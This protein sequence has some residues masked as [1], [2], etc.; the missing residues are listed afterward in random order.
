MEQATMDKLTGLFNRWI[1]IQMLEKEFERSIRYAFP[2][3]VCMLDIDHFKSINDRY[4]HVIG[5][6]VLRSVAGII[7]K[8]LRH[9]DISA[10]YGGEEFCA[11]LPHM[12][13]KNA[14][15]I[16]ERIRRAIESAACP[17]E[18]DVPARVTISIGITERNETVTD[19]GQMI[20]R[21]DSALY[22]AKNSG[23]NR[24]CIYP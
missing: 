6:H 7:G 21:A 4:G 11:I 18:G 20:E 12:N 5:D 23:R 13:L 15:I 14:K 17:V 9:S 3:S 22:A 16:M 8:E 19:P 10:R 1:L 2:L 24:T